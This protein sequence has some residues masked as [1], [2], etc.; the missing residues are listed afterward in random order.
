MKI[1]GI[2]PDVVVL[3]GNSRLFFSMMDVFK[4]LGHKVTIVGRHGR[5]SRAKALV[6]TPFGP[7]MLTIKEG[8]FKKHYEIEDFAK[9]HPVQ[10]L[11]TDDI[12]LE[13][14]PVSHPFMYFPQRVKRLLEKADFVFTDAEIYVKLPERVNG[15]ER[16]MIQY[17][18]FPLETLQP[19]EDK[20][21]RTVWAN[22][23]F[24]RK[25]IKDMWGLDADVVYP[26]TYCALYQNTRGFGDRPFDVVLLGRLDPSKIESVLPALEGFKVAVVGSAY[27]YEEQLPPWVKLNKNA[28]MAEVA[29]VLSQSKVYV[30]AKG[31]G[32]YDGGRKSE[33]EHFGQTI[34]EAMASG[35][36][37]IVPNV[38]G[39]V[40]I[41]G[42]DEQ[43]GYLFTS[44]EDL[45]TLI[46]DLL[47]SRSLWERK[48]ELALYRAKNFDV[49]V[50]SK[51]VQAL[52]EK[53]KK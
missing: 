21:P 40:E 47:N 34:V 10:H 4:G 5:E 22:S 46:E 35:C 19:V 23:E 20:P 15:V 32:T 2:H 29:C 28:S 41:V 26:P 53:M 49:S 7:Q 39:P 51:Q 44:T 17:V 50:V 38:G 24:T 30:H 3:A 36:V 8:M 1:V 9:Y 6:R 13:S 48:S 42:W 31:F 18:H 43:Y 12:R 37:P 25:H 52:L 16:K 11:T 27:G 33:A 45:R 14:I